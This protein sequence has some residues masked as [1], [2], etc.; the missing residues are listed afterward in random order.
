MNKRSVGAEKESVAADYLTRKGY[1]ILERNFRNR[2]GEI[3]LIARDKEYLV[4]IE[5]KY[6]RD[7][8]AGLPEDAVTARKQKTIC[9]VASFY[10]IKKGYQNEPSC[11]FDV[12]AIDGD[13]IRHYPNAFQFIV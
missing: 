5:V 3:D 2:D 7:Q 13:E 9:K 4:F 8:N 10:L 1:R 12:V 11:R 6:R